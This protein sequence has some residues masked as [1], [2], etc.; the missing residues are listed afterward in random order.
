[1][2]CVSLYVCKSYK[3]TFVKSLCLNVK[4]TQQTK[5]TKEIIIIVINKK[6][7]TIESI[8]LSSMKQQL[9]S[10]MSEKT[11]VMVDL[12]KEEEK[13]HNIFSSIKLLPI[14]VKST[15]EKS[16]NSNEKQSTISI[17]FRK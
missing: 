16:S 7:K 3:K 11:N 6:K 5:H 17:S 1:M 9:V 13:N 8:I 14:K 10:N 12:F 15:E 4:Q 2:L